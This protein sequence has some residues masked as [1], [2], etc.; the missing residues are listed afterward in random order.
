MVTSAPPARFL[1]CAFSA[2]TWSRISAI[3]GEITMVG[4]EIS[5]R[6]AGCDGYITKPL[7]IL[8]CDYPCDSGSAVIFTTEERARDLRQPAV[9]VDAM[10]LFHRCEPRDL[11]AAVRR[12]CRGCAIT[13]ADVLDLSRRTMARWV[14]QPVTGAYMKGLR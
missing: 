2:S 5:A 14:H 7:R 9:F 1:S 8:D 10:A 11:A 6:D 3:S 12:Y 13:A 4:D